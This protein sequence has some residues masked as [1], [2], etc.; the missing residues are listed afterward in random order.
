MDVACL[1]MSGTI[2]ARLGERDRAHQIDEQLA[3]LQFYPPRQEGDALLR[4]SYIAAALGDRDA[5]VT[6]LRGAFAKG[7]VYSSALHRQPDLRL[8]QG[9]AP[10][11]QLL[12][13]KG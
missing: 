11:E 5:A 8:L 4:R 9:Y 1:G 13:P 3:N 2:A 6:L 12:R 7:V 10:F